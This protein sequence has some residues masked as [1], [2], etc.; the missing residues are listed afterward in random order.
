[1]AVPRNRHSNARK[2]TKRAHSAITPK[3]VMRCKTCDT[4]HLPHTACPACGHYMG[5][6]IVPQKEQA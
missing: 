6:P 4:P 2:N 1:M 5:R 3:N